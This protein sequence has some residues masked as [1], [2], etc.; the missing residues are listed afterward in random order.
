MK[1]KKMD[2][3]KKSERSVKH[4]SNV[5]SEKFEKCTSFVAINGFIQSH[6]PALLS[7]N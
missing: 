1:V 7:K 4:S 5:S 6:S 2:P 3:W